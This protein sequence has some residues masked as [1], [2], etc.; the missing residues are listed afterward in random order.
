MWFLPRTEGSAPIRSEPE[1]FVQAFARRIES[2]LLPHASPRRSRYSVSR[3]GRDGLAF[4]AADWLTAV[5]VGLNDVELATSAGQIRYAIEYRRWAGYVV[6]L[7]G[8]I[9]V[10][11]AVVFLMM[12]QNSAVG[13]LM[14]FFWGFVWP[15]IMVALH[16]R[17]LRMLMERII[18]EVDLDAR[19]QSARQQ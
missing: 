16:K 7:C 19:T 14:V 11:L 2:G 3:Q 10:V 4:R 17:P 8:A 18:A 15:W 12:D 1:S 5:N 13:W 6:L 9:G